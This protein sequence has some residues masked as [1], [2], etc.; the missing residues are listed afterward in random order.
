MQYELNN[1]EL[2]PEVPFRLKLFEKWIVYQ[3]YV[4]NEMFLLINSSVCE[5]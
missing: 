1:E 4:V 2:D 3:P 5:L